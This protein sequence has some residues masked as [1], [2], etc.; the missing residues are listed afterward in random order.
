[1]PTIQ[2]RY[3]PQP[4]ALTFSGPATYAAGGITVTTGL[5]FVQ[6]AAV[7]PVTPGTAPDPQWRLTRNSPADGQVACQFFARNYD[8]LTALG[9]LAGLPALVSSRATSGG[10]D[11]NNSH[12]HSAAHDH[13]VS[14]ASTAPATAGATVLVAVASNISAHT[15]TV[16]LPNLAVTTGSTAHTHTWDFLYQHQHSVTQ[17]A[18]DAGVTELSVGSTAL[19]GTTWRMLAVGV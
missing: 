11:D 16:D 13:V 1:M 7:R 4:V 8:K 10:T 9:S 6:F 2:D 12:T 3:D 5:A 15:H 17:T 14:P 19:S 18:T